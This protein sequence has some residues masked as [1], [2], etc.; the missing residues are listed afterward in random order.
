MRG[1]MSPLGR[2]SKSLRT[3]KA[4]H[5]W[6]KLSLK[7]PPTCYSHIKGE[8][9]HIAGSRFKVEE[10]E[11]E[12]LLGQVHDIAAPRYCCHEPQSPSTIMVN[13]DSK[14]SHTTQKIMGHESYWVMS[15]S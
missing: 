6:V 10:R 1:G 7:E 4:C 12:R 5:P 14:E 8:T 15:R 9:V 13:R 3:V 11:C 2:A